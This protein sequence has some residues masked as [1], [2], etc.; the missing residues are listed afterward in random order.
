MSGVQGKI[1]RG[2]SKTTQTKLPSRA[3]TH[4]KEKLVGKDSKPSSSGTKETKKRKGGEGRRTQNPR[5]SESSPLSQNGRVRTPENALCQSS[6]EGAGKLSV[7]NCAEFWEL[8]KGLQ[9][10]EEHLF[11]KNYWTFVTTAGCGS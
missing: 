5:T 4:I 6:K 3:K 1:Q 10:S 9:Q 7:S 8:T 11:K 2:W